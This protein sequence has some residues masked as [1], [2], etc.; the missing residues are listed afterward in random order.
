PKPPPHTRAHARAPP[1]SSA[2]PLTPAAEA[3]DDLAAQTGERRFS[4]AARLTRGDGIGGRNEI[5][6]SAALARVLVLIKGGMET[7]AALAAV[8]RGVPRRQRRAAKR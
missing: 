4:H 5:D 6:D 1:R 3:L 8:T 2:S 7:P